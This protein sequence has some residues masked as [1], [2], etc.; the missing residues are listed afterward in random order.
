MLSPSLREILKGVSRSFYLTLWA[1]PPEIRAQLGLGYLFC[2]AA[3]TIADTDLLPPS[4]RLKYLELFREQFRTDDISWTV[5]A[6]IRGRLAEHQEG[7][8]ERLL[9]RRL[10]D[11]FRAFLTFSAEDRER[12]RQLVHTLTRG[13]E[14]DLSCFPLQAP[15]DPQALP[16]QDHLDRYCYYVAGVVGEFWTR[17]LMGHFEMLKKRDEE[18]MRRLGM[19]FGQGLQMTNILKDL[20]SDL[21]RGRCYLPQTLLKAQGVAPRDLR[22]DLPAEKL[23]SLLAPEVRLTLSHLQE[24][25]AYILAIPRRALRLRLA[26]LWPHLFAVKTLDRIYHAH[27]L[28]NPRRRVKI[29]RREVYTV[30]GLTPLLAFSNRLLTFYY[31]RLSSPLRKAVEAEQA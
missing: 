28:L 20:A 10:E 7:S 26:C 11:C 5:L 8:A 30:M 22:E 6:E 16:T 17:M 14:M 31:R 12:I 9:L 1:V 18:Q 24:G 19:R 25:W 23:R 29:S 3:D 15:H 13:M 27:G 2:R 21:A 4:E